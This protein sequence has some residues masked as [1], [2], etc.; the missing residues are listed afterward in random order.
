MDLLLVN[1]GNRDGEAKRYKLKDFKGPIQNKQEREQL[2]SWRC[3]K[4]SDGG[5]M[6]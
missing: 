4:F 5:L 2:A 3:A 1:Q 6:F